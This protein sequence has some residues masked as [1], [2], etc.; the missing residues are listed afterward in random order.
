M[1]HH[2]SRPAHGGGHV[3]HGGGHGGAGVQHGAHALVVVHAVLQGQHQRAGGQ[4]RAHL[5][6]G[7]FQVGRLHAEQHHVC[8]LHRAGLGA[9]RQGHLHVHLRRLQPQP[10]VAHGQYVGGPPDERDGMARAGEQGAKVAAHGARAH[11]GETQGCGGGIGAGIWCGR[12]SGLGHGALCRWVP[13][14]EQR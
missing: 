12:W 2:V 3:D 1:V 7:V 9:G 11:H 8:A 14:E 10:V 13:Q 4:V 6:R 5:L